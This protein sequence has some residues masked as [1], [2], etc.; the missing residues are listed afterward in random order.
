MNECHTCAKNS[1][2]W[3]TQNAYTDGRRQNQKARNTKSKKPAGHRDKNTIIEIR[4]DKRKKIVTATP[5]HVD[6]AAA[7]SSSFNL[8]TILFFIFFFG[9]T[10]E[11]CITCIERNTH[12]GIGDGGAVFGLTVDFLG[13]A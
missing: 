2:K 1:E 11:T 7:A 4:D 3:R 12:I 8:P 10:A 13:L 6:T 9:F 5:A